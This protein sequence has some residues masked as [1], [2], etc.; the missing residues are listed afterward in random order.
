[1]PEEEYITISEFAHRAGVSVQAIYKRLNGGLKPFLKDDGGEKRLSTKGLELYRET[2][3]STQDSTV[4]SPL[5]AE[6]IRV[7][8]KT[9]DNLENQ[10]QIKDR[11]IEQLTTALMNQQ[12]LHKESIKMLP[13]DEEDDVEKEI[14]IRTDIHG[15]LIDPSPII[16]KAYEAGRKYQKKQ[17][18]DEINE[19]RH[20]FYEQKVKLSEEQDRVI[21]SVKQGVVRIEGGEVVNAE[22]LPE[23]LRSFVEKLLQEGYLIGFNEARP[24]WKKKKI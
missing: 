15:R 13:S 10:M 1:M 4:E 22:K 3:D 23:N 19:M 11:H 9:I 2:E 16:E 24:F 18:E 17:D 14:K 6:I 5:N 7:L 21:Q 8:K 20:H 12:V